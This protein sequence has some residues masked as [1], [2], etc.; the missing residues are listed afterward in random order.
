VT[1]KLQV[2]DGVVHVIAERFWDPRARI[3]ARPP[4]GGS[5]DFH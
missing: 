1:G 3:D 2:Q 4:S 5:R